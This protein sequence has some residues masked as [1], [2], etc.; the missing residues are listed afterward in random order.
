MPP[1]NEEE[2]SLRWL[3]QSLASWSLSSWGGQSTSASLI[4]AFTDPVTGSGHP[5][6]DPGLAPLGTG[7][8]RAHLH[9]FVSLYSILEIFK[10]NKDAHQSYQCP[11]A[12]MFHH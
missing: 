6:V 9:E 10:A 3:L 4:D 8:S 1:H 7:V 11:P 2:A 5:V 12:L